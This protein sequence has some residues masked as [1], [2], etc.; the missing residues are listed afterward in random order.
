MG[1]KALYQGKIHHERICR[2][3]PTNTAKSSYLLRVKA[4]FAVG[5]RS[6]TFSDLE[7]QRPQKNDFRE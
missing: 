4:V 3:K 5:R 6:Q 1:K 7:T 2:F